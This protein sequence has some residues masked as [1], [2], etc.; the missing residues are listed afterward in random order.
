[1]LVNENKINQYFHIP[2]YNLLSYPPYLHIL[3]VK[4]TVFMSPKD[5]VVEEERLFLQQKTF[6]RL[7]SGYSTEIL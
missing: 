2:Q 1:M 6:L 7:R 4:Y 5:N 3:T